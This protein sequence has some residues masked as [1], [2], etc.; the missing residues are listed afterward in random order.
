MPAAEKDSA[1]AAAV[2]VGEQLSAKK[3]MMNEL[4]S[5]KDFKGAA[6][7][8]EEVKKIESLAEQ[9]VRRTR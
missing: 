8:E 6:A 7:A 4:A 1:G 5:N 3:K 9:C 2:L